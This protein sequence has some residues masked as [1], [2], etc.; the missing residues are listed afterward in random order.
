MPHKISQDRSDTSENPNTGKDGLLSGI[1]DFCRHGTLPAFAFSAAESVCRAWMELEC[2]Q[3]RFLTLGTRVGRELL[4]S[5]KE[6]QEEQWKQRPVCDCEPHACSHPWAQIKG[7]QSAEVTRRTAGARVRALLW[8]CKEAALLSWL[9][10]VKGIC[11]VPAP[12]PLR[13]KNAAR[14]I[15][16][17]AMRLWGQDVTQRILHGPL[18]TRSRFS[19]G[20]LA[21]ING[22]LASAC[23]GAGLGAS[24]AAGFG[25][26]SVDAAIVA[27]AGAAVFS[28]ASVMAISRCCKGHEDGS[29]GLVLSAADANALLLGVSFLGMGTV[30]G[31]YGIGKTK[32]GDVIL[33]GS[34]C[35]GCD[36]DGFANPHPSPIFGRC[37]EEDGKEVRPMTL[38]HIIACAPFSLTDCL[39]GCMGYMPASVR[40]AMADSR[41][42][43]AA[44]RGGALQAHSLGTLEARLLKANMA[45]S[46]T[47]TLLSPPPPFGWEEGTKRT[48]GRF[49]P[50]CSGP[51]MSVAKHVFQAPVTYELSDICEPDRG[52]VHSRPYYLS[53]LA[54]ADGRGDLLQFHRLRRP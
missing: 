52:V 17:R 37:H 41:V 24:G 35:Q 49:D 29:K 44:H 46:G 51:L 32:L 4:L 45:W 34:F 11:A 16:G 25:A 39:L 9:E 7:M 8:A 3:N 53:H 2:S 47:M 28:T 6:H 31:R 19:A 23:A 27:T 20:R 1:A 13:G 10:N 30:G 15:V 21:R 36:F 5:F 14:A 42:R 33:A 40:V 22:V 43:A 54:G 38:S 18:R 50:I 48:C 26:S 12:E